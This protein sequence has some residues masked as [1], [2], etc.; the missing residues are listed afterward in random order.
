MPDIAVVL[1]VGAAIILVGILVIFVTSQM[2]KNSK[3]NNVKIGMTETE[4]MNIVGK[5]KS[6]SVNGNFVT[7]I[8]I[9]KSGYSKGIYLHKTT[10]TITFKNGKVDSINKNK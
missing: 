6:R 5:P 1:L 3:F 2:H 10:Y 7:G 8:W 4:V 9:H